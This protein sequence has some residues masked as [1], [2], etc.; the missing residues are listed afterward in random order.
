[1]AIRVVITELNDGVFQFELD[2]NIIYNNKRNDLSIDS[3]TGTYYCHFKTAEGANILK[4]Q[5][6]LID[7]VKIVSIDDDEYY[8]TTVA[9]IFGYLTDIN[10][11][12]WIGSGGGG[13][14]GGVDK[15]KDLLD[16][17]GYTGNDGKV[18]V[19]NSALMRLDPVYLYNYRLFTQ[20]E[21][22]A[23]EALTLDMVGNT[24]TVANIGGFPRIVIS[25][26]EATV[27]YY[28]YAEKI[29]LF[30]K[31]YINDV[32]NPDENAFIEKGDIAYGLLEN[33][34]IQ[35]GI[36]IDILED[37]ETQNWN[38]YEIIEKITYNKAT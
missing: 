9:G 5:N 31:G 38:N 37:G 12:S 32:P 6:I 29:K 34:I 28:N 8:P 18:P 23:S 21:D 7:E 24:F 10:Y 27:P 35:K 20:L 22:V 1:M 26:P 17:F 11:F 33:G 2:G 4:I 15:F 30:Q 25:A 14:G 13:G 3:S 19:V 36:F 16:T